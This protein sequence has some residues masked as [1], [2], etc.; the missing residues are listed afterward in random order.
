M[1]K[2]ERLFL[3]EIKWIKTKEEQKMERLQIVDGYESFMSLKETEIAIKE[4]KD[5]FERALAK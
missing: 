5:F 3:L 4:T 2:D 1:Y